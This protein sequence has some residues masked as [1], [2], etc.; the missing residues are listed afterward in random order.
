MLKEQNLM[1]KFCSYDQML[2]IAAGNQ[3]TI[4]QTL[5]RVIKRIED[6]LCHYRVSNNT[7]VTLKVNELLK[8]VVTWGL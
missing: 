2:G 4:S 5:I 1:L 8:L 3:S 7:I 6:C